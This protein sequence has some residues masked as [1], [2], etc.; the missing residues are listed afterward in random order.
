MTGHID[1]L[2]RYVEKVLF[3]LEGLIARRYFLLPIPARLSPI[4]KACY[5]KKNNV[6]IKEA[7]MV[8]HHPQW[9]WIH[10]F[11]K[12]SFYILNI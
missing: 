2:N 4:L 12:N 5:P 9:L 10:K 7:F 1:N 8:R 3:R 11:I 6:I